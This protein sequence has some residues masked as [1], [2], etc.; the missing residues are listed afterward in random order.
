MRCRASCGKCSSSAPSQS[1]RIKCIA[2]G[3][4]HC[5][6]LEVVLKCSVMITKLSMGQ[7]KDALYMAGEW[8]FMILRSFPTLFCDLTSS[9]QCF[10]TNTG[11]Q[12]KT[13]PSKGKKLF[14]T[15]INV[16]PTRAAAP[17][18]G[19]SQATWKRRA[20]AC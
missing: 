19:H 3:L 4:E 20:V 10:T 1:R 2:S 7:H 17:A 12:L 14:L 9:S 8:N 11:K 5:E 6:D 15:F 13:S 18:V 16:L